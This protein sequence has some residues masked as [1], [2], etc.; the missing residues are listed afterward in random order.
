MFLVLLDAH[1]ILHRAYHALPPLTNK[2]GKPTNA[3]YGFTTMLLRLLSELQPTHLAAAFDMPGPTF[4]QKIWTQYQE[5]RPEA[6]SN[7]IA[8]FPLAHELLDELNIAHYQCE[9]YEADDI[10]GTLVKQFQDL[11]SEEQNGEA[12]IVTGDRDLLQLVNDKVKVLVPVRGFGQTKIY[13]KELIRKEFGVEPWQW[14]DVKALK[15]DPSDNYPGVRGIG[16]KTAEKLIREYETLENLFAHLDELARSDPQTARKLAE[17][18]EDAGLGKKLAQI[19]TNAPVRLDWETAQVTRINWQRGAGYMRE[20]LGFKSI[21]QRIERQKDGKEKEHRS[22]AKGQVKKGPVED[23][24][25][26]GNCQKAEQLG[27]V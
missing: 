20:R 19:V 4:R 16:P 6:A 2:E 14:V 13:T 8:Q 5:K 23:K 17:G 10:L 25:N 15:G 3:I 9:G 24:N 22:T 1:A 7:L 26:R 11:E 27:L 21:A 18:A 12:V